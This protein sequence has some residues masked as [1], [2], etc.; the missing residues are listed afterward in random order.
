MLIVDK[1][2][3]SFGEKIAVRGLSLEVRDGEVFGFLGPNGAGKTTTIKMVVGLMKPESGVISI[4][5]LTPD[6]GGTEYRARFGYIPDGPYLPEKLRSEEVLHFS[7]ACYGIKGRELEERSIAALKEFGLEDQRFELVE[8][9]SHGMRQRLLFATQLLHRPS[10][11]VVDEPMVGLD[12]E[13]A[14]KARGL[15][16]SMADEGRAVFMSTH[17]LD[18]AEKVCDRIGIINEGRMI[19]MGDTKELLRNSKGLE[20]VFLKL[21]R[22]V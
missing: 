14:L 18:V 2:Y 13:S 11:L 12:P 20:E 10:L 9:L 4:D 16:R 5:G 19:A 6:G 7:G 22:E 17:N 3:K 8:S 1:L 15:F 21:T